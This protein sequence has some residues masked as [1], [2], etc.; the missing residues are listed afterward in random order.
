MTNIR[1][2][3]KSRTVNE[4]ADCIIDIVE[5]GNPSPSKTDIVKCVLEGSLS[6]SAPV[7]V[8]TML[9]DELANELDR[10]FKESVEQAAEKLNLPY[11]MVSK[12]FYRCKEIPTDLEGSRKLVA[13]F[14]NG[15]GSKAVGVRFVEND[16]TGIDPL[17]A[18][19]MDKRTHVVEKTVIKHKENVI[20]AVKQGALPAS[21]AIGER[22][23]LTNENK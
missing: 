10:Y 6:E 1:N 19:A 13:S 18:I 22:N 16:E 15:R 9:E 8:R 21:Y 12:H 4:F 20:K 14:G 3:K 5:A 23:L 2:T 7:M 11:H 17:Y